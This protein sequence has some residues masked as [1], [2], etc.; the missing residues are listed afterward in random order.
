M[1]LPNDLKIRTFKIRT[2]LISGFL[3]V[4]LIVAVVGIIGYNATYKM[5]K[6]Q[7]EFA[8]RR[9]PSVQALLT[10]S[11]SQTSI[12]DSVNLISLN[13]INEIDYQS[14]L[15]NIGDALKKA[16]SGWETYTAMPA[17]TEEKEM[18]EYFMLF[19][20]TW[21]TNI[22]DFVDLANQYVNGKIKCTIFRH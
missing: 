21:K 22:N 1:K 18:Q 17:T 6:V 4:A 8:E 3:A 10:V 14:Q 13:A 9:L 5:Y 16:E 11:E 20:N 15:K 2:K 7:N 12:D 19:W